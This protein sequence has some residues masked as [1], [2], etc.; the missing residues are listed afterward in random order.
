MNLIVCDYCS[1][2]PSAR[3]HPTRT[4]SF[5]S[6][7]P[8]LKFRSTKIFNHYPQLNALSFTGHTVFPI[9]SIHNLT[10]VLMHSKPLNACFCFFSFFRKC[11]AGQ[12]FSGFSYDA[13][14][15]SK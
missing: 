1:N 9:G 13:L 8:S 14:N 3:I 10:Y 7:L 6:M 15:S 12:N 4:V 11:R 2:G 5:M